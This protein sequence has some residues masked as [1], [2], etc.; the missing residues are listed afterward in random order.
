M[1]HRYLNFL[2]LT[3]VI[4]SIPLLFTCT[5]EQPTENEVKRHYVDCECGVNVDMRVG[6]ILEIA[7]SSNL[8]E[9]WR[10]DTQSTYLEL[11]N[12][13]RTIDTTTEDS[14]IVN[15]SWTFTADSA[16]GSELWF[17]LYLPVNDSV[18]NLFVVSIFV[19]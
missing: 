14:I 2:P 9:E 16:G 15:R 18:I 17:E 19:Q 10:M 4:F 12:L 11:T 8:D 13:G 6:E 1:K 7:T 5:D 3:I